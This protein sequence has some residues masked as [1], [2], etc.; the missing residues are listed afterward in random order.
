M[1]IMKF[2]DHTLFLTKN[3]AVHFPS[4]CFHYNFLSH[5][6]CTFHCQLVVTILDVNDVTPKFEKKSYLKSVREDNKELE[7]SDDRKILTVS[8]KDDDVGDNARILY[9]ITKGNEEGL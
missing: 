6:I 4:Q 3:L 1:Y 7:P 5:C 8:A 9:N 2:A